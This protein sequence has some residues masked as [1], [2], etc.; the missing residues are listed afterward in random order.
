ML[1]SRYNVLS[2]LQRGQSEHQ[3]HP[4]KL[5]I[6]CSADA[7]APEEYDRPRLELRLPVVLQ[8]SLP[9]AGGLFRLIV[10]CAEVEW[11]G[12]SLGSK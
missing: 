10:C 5:E 7:V 8:E 1:D 4:K 6:H 2:L 9:R 11:R 12:A 3:N